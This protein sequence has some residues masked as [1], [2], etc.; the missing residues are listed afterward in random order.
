MTRK[1]DAMRGQTNIDFAYGVSVF[2]LA[3]I[4][5]FSLVPNLLAPF[6]APVGNDQTVQSNRASAQLL[7]DLS[8]AGSSNELD[9]GVTNDFFDDADLT[10][11]RGRFGFDDTTRVNVTLQTGT[12]ER[13]VGPGYEGQSVGSALRVATGYDDATY[14][15]CSPTCRIVVRVW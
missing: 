12:G 3:V 14:G 5:T 4:V 15:E 11:M 8:V 7:A 1:Q 13:T 2:I 9:T 6:Q 10:S